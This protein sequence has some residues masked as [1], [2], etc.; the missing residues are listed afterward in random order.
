MANIS[1][2]EDRLLIGYDE[3]AK[4]LTENEFEITKGT[5]Y[6]LCHRGK[7]PPNEGK[8]GRETR[9]LASKVLAWAQDRLYGR[10]KVAPVEMMP[11]P[12][13]VRAEWMPP[14]SGAVRSPLIAEAMPP[15]QQLIDFDDADLPP[16]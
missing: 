5:L 2:T 12:R 16:F 11:P 1:Q 9:F 4:F 8:W 6:K 14:E 10:T 7:G 15:D 3:V 13:F